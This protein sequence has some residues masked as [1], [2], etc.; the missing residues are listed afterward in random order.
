MWRLLCNLCLAGQLQ[1]V[2]LFSLYLAPVIP[3]SGS[4]NSDSLPQIAPFKNTILQPFSILLQS[5]SATLI[6]PLSEPI[7]CAS[8]RA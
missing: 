1:D 7:W 6:N 3:L 8:L 4:L 2:N 5:D